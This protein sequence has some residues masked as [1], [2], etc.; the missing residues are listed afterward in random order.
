MLPLHSYRQ[1]GCG[2]IISQNVDF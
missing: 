1:P 2:L